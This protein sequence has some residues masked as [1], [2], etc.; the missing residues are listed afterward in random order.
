V[1]TL[2]TK[3]EAIANVSVIVMALA[4]G[5]VVLT[6]YA[7]SYHT[8]RSV[9]AGD[10]LAN[11]PGLDWSQHRRT[12][13]LVL[14]LGCH[15]C[16][17]SIPFYQKL[18]QARAHDND[19]IEVVAVFPNEAEIVRRFTTE[20]NLAIRS[21]PG[22]PLDKLGVKATPTLIL[23]NDEGQVQQSWVGV[24]TARQEIEVLKLASGS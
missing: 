14:S 15:F 8:P 20:E 17:D 6:R 24:L 12:L 21:V 3:L 5:G 2:K 22:V 7:T 11:F 18:V 10:H 1:S 19:G 9:A 23:V 4:V 16:Q 13:L